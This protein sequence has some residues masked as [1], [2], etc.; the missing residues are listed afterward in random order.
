MQQNMQKLKGF[1]YILMQP[2]ATQY[3]FKIFFF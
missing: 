2:I 1:E 3:F